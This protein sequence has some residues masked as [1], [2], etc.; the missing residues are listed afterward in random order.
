MVLRFSRC[1]KGQVNVVIGLLCVLVGV[2]VYIFCCCSVFRKNFFKKP[3]VNSIRVLKERVSQF[4]KFSLIFSSH[5]P[6]RIFLSVNA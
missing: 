5:R 6:F 4:H 3:V 2:C 1:E